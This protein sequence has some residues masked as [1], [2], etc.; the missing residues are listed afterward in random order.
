MGFLF[1]RGPA[2]LGAGLA[3]LILASVLHKPLLGSPALEGDEPAGAPRATSLGEGWRAAAVLLGGF[4]PLAIDVLWLRADALF[5][6]GR[7]WELATLFRGILAL[8]P[9]NTAV[10]EYASWHLAYNV[11]LAE[12]DPERRFEWFVQGI[13]ILEE[14]IELGLQERRLRTSGGRMFLDPSRGEVIPGFEAKV[15]AAFGRPPLRMA[16]TWL[17][18]AVRGETERARAHVFLLAA[19]EGLRFEAAEAGRLE[20]AARWRERKRSVLAEA[21]ARFPEEDW[22]FAE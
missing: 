11:A 4:R 6:Q 19:L 20:A 18:E 13:R 17:E 14:G 5:R 15:E 9:S 3:L 1:S 7:L 8:E 22:R 21:K 16:V 10:R 2:A 12:R